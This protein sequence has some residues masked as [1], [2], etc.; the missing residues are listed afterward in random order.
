MVSSVKDGTHVSE[1]CL[2]QCEEVEMDCPSLFMLVVCTKKM[3][4]F[5]LITD[6]SPLH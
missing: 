2:I 1:T 4:L 3:H 5:I 6:K